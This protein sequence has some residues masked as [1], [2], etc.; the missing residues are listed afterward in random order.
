MDATIL[1]A[2]AAAAGMI[3]GKLFDTF[4]AKGKN[5]TDTT[6]SDR[7][8]IMQETAALRQ[9]MREEIRILRSEVS[10]LREENFQLRAENTRLL[11]RISELEDELKRMRRLAGYSE[12]GDESSTTDIEEE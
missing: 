10:Q 3:I 12:K 9:E 7:Q 5:K 6:I 2:I 4:M 1:A 8:M 11:L